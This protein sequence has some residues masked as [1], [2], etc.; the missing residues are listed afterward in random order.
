VKLRILDVDKQRMLEAAGRLLLEVVEEDR[1]LW[2]QLHVLFVARAVEVT[3]GTDTTIGVGD[4]C[5][6]RKDGSAA[7]G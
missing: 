3:G 1:R 5:V 2:R 4:G 7:R 6:D